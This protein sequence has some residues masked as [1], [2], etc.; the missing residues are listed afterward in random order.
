MKSPYV[1][2]II[3][4][5]NGME[6]ISQ[7]LNSLLNQTYTN[8]EIIIVDNDSTDGSADFIEKNFPSVKLIRNKDNVGF[9]EGNNIGISHSK[10]DLIALFNP[11]AVADKYWL[12]KLVPAIQSS[13]EIGGVTG[14]LYYLG[15]RF[16][17]DA[18]FCTWSKVNRFSASTYNF[19]KNEP[20]SRVDYMTGAAMI[21]KKQVIDKIGFL[22]PDYFLYFDETDWCA[23]M[24]RAGYDLMYI[25]T[26][27]AWH[28]VSG[29]VS[30]S[31]NKIYYME[32]SRM[33][34]A[35]KNFDL[36]YLPIFFGIFFVESLGVFLRDL[37][38][39]N[40]MRTKIRFHV[41]CWNLANISKT[42]RRRRED[43]DKIRN[44]STMRSYNMS[45]PLQEIKTGTDM[46]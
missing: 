38:N 22:D 1:S 6:F 32:R 35:I 43:F 10:G 36:L 34:F 21:V 26:A 41:I 40:F 45:L 14:K 27:I 30:D 31:T 9:A 17:K 2:I 16:G 8:F 5:W 33:R 3:V 42:L 7:C 44:H 37:K 29:I 28:A 25:P 24:I 12:E 46:F 18:V 13:D 23:R 19:H 4:N 20:I 15:D 39:R 11:D